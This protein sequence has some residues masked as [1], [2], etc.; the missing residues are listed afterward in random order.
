[1]TQTAAHL[2]HSLIKCTKANLVAVTSNISILPLSNLQPVL[3]TK[4]HI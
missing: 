1:M 3:S 4:K 2:K